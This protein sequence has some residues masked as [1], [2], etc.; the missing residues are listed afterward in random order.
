MLLLISFVSVVGGSILCPIAGN[1]LFLY[2][3]SIKPALIGNLKVENFHPASKKALN[4]SPKEHLKG[5]AVSLV[6][7]F[8]NTK[9]FHFKFMIKEK[10]FLVHS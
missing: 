9:Y 7:G 5:K 4:A 3:D 2:R 6:L 1:Q 8:G 10:P